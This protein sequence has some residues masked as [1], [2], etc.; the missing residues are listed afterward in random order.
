MKLEAR[1]RTAWVDGL[2]LQYHDLLL[3][4]ESEEESRLIDLLGLPDSYV[5]GQIR[6][7]DGYGQ[8]YILLQPPF[9]FSRD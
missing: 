4:P 5:Q 8:H 1:E 2:L 6:L 7:A 9:S 3:I